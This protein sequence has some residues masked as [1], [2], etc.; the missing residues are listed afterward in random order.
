MYQNSHSFIACLFAFIRWPFIIFND[1]NLLFIH[2][3]IIKVM[4][5]FAIETSNHYY[6][7]V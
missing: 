6:V 4:P 2:T 1:K 7:V 3:T 5:R